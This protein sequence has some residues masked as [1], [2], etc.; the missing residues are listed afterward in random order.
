[1]KKEDIQFISDWLHSDLDIELNIKKGRYKGGILK[2][3]SNAY[4]DCN[5]KRYKGDKRTIGYYSDKDNDKVYDS[6]DSHI[7]YGEYSLNEVIS[8]LKSLEV[9]GFRLTVI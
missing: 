7:F 2:L 3:E 1:M 8:I 5:G 4:Y 9:N 6:L